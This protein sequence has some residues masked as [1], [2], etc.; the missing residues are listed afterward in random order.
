MESDILIKPHGRDLDARF[1]LNRLAIPSEVRDRYPFKNL[2][3]FEIITHDR[4]I[5]GVAGVLGGHLWFGY[6][7]QV[8]YTS[9]EN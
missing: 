6:P 3:V 1:E 9:R 8:D 7:V 2:V 5:R 4:L